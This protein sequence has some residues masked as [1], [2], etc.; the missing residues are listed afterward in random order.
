MKRA[1]FS[2]DQIIRIHNEAEVVGTIREAEGLP[3]AQHFGTDLLPLAQNVWR[4]GCFR[5]EEAESARTREQ[6]TQEDGRRKFAGYPGAE[7]A[8][9]EKMVSLADPRRG[10]EH[11]ER[12]LAISEGRA[13]QVV[14]IVHSTERRLPGRVE[15]KSWR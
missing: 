11:L 1:R 7:G 3:G 15:E 5:D 9:L 8:E 13:C 4:D 6:R 2:E 14:E 12:T 10:E